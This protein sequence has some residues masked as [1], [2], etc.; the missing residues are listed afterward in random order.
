M[1]T[2]LFRVAQKLRKIQFGNNFVLCICAH[3]MTSKILASVR[4]DELVLKMVIEV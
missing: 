3:A 1:A 2:P 4:F